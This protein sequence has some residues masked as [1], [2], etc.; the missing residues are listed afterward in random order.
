VSSIVYLVLSKV[1]NLHDADDI[2]L[3]HPYPLGALISA[4]TFLLAFR[5]NFSYN[6]Y[7]ESMTAVHLMHSKWLDVGMELAAF[8]LQAAIYDQRRPPAFG[9]HPEINSLERARERFNEPTLEEL[10]D[11]LDDMETVI[12][13]Q[14]MTDSSA[15]FRRKPTRSFLLPEFARRRKRPTKPKL[16]PPMKSINGP[17]MKSINAVR[18]TYSPNASIHRFFAMRGSIGKAASL[19]KLQAKVQAAYGSHRQAW[20]PNKPPLFLQEAAHLLSLMSAVAFSTLRNDLE[21]AYSPLITFTP[22]APFPHVD[23][24]AYTADVRR[25]WSTTNSR[26]LIILRYISGWSRT[27]KDRTLY[28]AARPF[29]VIGG[30][31]DSEIE[32]LQA[33]RG[34]LAKVALVSMWLQEFMTRE[35]LAGS[36][37]NVATPVLSR[38]YQHISEGMLGYNQARKVRLWLTPVGRRRSSSLS[39][40]IHWKGRLHSISVC[41]RPYVSG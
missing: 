19:E 34:P 35:Y 36:T 6:R 25:D 17:P 37:G 39:P 27:V 10:Q 20:D 33:A 5:A 12:A 30:V 26:P 4:L 8:H 24:D 11:Q 15:L 31:S 28:N 32:L 22:G 18:S 3:L 41:A 40:A 21:Q 2:L 16:G 7:W 13:E 29:R 1:I 14:E 23:P 38:M 9:N